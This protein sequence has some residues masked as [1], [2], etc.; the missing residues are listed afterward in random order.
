M[1]M[2][3][4]LVTVLMGDAAKPSPTPKTATATSP[5]VAASASVDDFVALSYDDGAGHKLPY[6]LFIPRGYDPEGTYPLVVFLHGAGGRGTDNRAQ[7]TDQ[8]APLVFVQPGN[9]ARWPAFM[10]APQ[11]PPDQQWVDMP[12]GTPS[13][14]GKQPVAVTWPMRAAMNLIDRL[15]NDYPAIDAR[16]LYVTGMS[17]GGYGTWD[18]AVRHPTKWK[19]AVTVC[20]GYDE[21]TIGPIVQA[22][23]P[24]WAFHAADDPT[25]PVGR[26]REM[27]AALRARGATPR[28]T[29][30]PA[31]EHHGHFSWRPAYADPQLLPWMFGPAG[32]DATPSGATK[33]K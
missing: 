17:M 19:A 30:Y 3:L 24:I 31:S 27:I 7:I 23:L 32:G 33:R 4:A 26:S 6:R 16:R 28:Y 2:V 25:V 22:R 18:A 10:V 1:V 15:Q 5:S 12:W 21:L 8:A 14:K 11:C 20:G 13:G 9:Q 29:E